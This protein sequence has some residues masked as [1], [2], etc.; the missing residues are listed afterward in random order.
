MSSISEERKAPAPPKTKTASK[1]LGL[2]PGADTPQ[3]PSSDSEDGGR[4][5]DEEAMYAE[6]G[7]KLT[8]EHNGVVMSLGSEADLAAWKKERQKNWPTQARMGEREEERRRVGEER[9][10]LLA[11][12]A[13]FQMSSDRN[14]SKPKTR[15]GNGYGHRTRN[16]AQSQNSDQCDPGMTHADHDEENE[17]QKTKREVAEQTATLDELRRKV[18]QS[19]ARYR[20]ARAQQ[21]QYEKNESTIKPETEDAEDLGLTSTFNGENDDDPDIKAESVGTTV[22]DGS[23][24]SSS[25]SSSVL[26][27]DSSSGA[28]SDDGPPEEVA[29]KPPVVAAPSQDVPIC[30]YFAASGYCRDRDSCR[31]RHELPPNRLDPKWRPQQPSQDLLQSRASRPPAIESKIEKKSIFQRLMDQEQG[32]ENRLALQVIKYLGKAGFFRVPS[33]EVEV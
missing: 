14:K 10:R 8:F 26:S 22:S 18:K 12:A 7:T 25:E 27:S 33:E 24:H 6:L 15:R 29:S 9:K 17:L 30:R 13:S 4:E 20:K 28:D 2:T 23:D 21:D 3:Y 11:S 1:G 32:E 5:V 31:Y 19:E 16:E